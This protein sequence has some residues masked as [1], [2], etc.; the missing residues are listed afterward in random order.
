MSY[1]RPVDTVERASISHGLLSLIVIY[2]I[3][4]YIHFNFELIDFICK[5]EKCFK[6]RL[7]N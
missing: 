7:K 3:I 1:S 4:L 2:V 6:E 5:N